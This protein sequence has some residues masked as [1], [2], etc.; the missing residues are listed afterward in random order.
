MT[1]SAKPSIDTPGG[2]QQRRVIKGLPRL[3]L[4]DIDRKVELQAARDSLYFWWWSFLRE[5]LD[6]RRAVSGR[7]EEPWARMASDFGRLGDHFDSWWFETGRGLFKE[8]VA[9]PKV[10]KLEHGEPANYEGINRKLVIELPL[11]IRRATILKQVN[12][13]LDAE[14]NEPDKRYFSNL[15]VH[16]FSTARRR[17]YPD[18]RIRITSF[19]TLLDVWQERKKSPSVPWWEVGEK[20]RLSPVYITQPT[21]TE[22]EVKYKH[23]LMSLIVQRHYRRAKALIE[24]AAKGDFPRFK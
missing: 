19:K 9:I 17:I 8:R 24:F 23:R 1:D 15:R 20:L 7:K 3:P 13:L 10:R 12:T 4:V 16:A 18:Q 21:D 11:T 22:E 14:L 5:S 2:K 6:Y